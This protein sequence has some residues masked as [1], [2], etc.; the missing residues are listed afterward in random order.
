MSSTAGFVS[1]F[2]T[3][4]TARSPISARSSLMS[5]GPRTNDCATRSTPRSSARASPSRSRSVTAGRLSRSAGTF[6]PWPERTVPPRTHSVRTTGPSTAVTVSSTAPSASRMRS[7]ARRSCARSGY[8]VAAPSSVASPSGRS[9]NPCPGT[10]FSGSGCSV[11]S[12][13]FGPG[14]S[15][16]T[17]S[18]PSCFASTARTSST[19]R[20]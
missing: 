3:I 6:T 13:T 17:A 5:C 1:I 2:A 9:A 11:P 4:G 15:A 12:R 19:A 18:A 10:S 14:R 8:V 7:P 20:A 16:I